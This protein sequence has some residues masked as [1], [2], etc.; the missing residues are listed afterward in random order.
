[1]NSKILTKHFG[2]AFAYDAPKVWNE[3][4]DNICSDNYLFYYSEKNYF[5]PNPVASLLTVCTQNLVTG[6][7]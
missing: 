5:K 7:V 4:P 6:A 1:M 3:L 2:V